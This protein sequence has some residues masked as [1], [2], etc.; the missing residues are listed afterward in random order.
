M[1]TKRSSIVLEWEVAV[2]TTD[3]PGQHLSFKLLSLQ[4]ARRPEFGHPWRVH[5]V[6]V[7]NMPFFMLSYD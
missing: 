2:E 1:K 6:Y 3:L 5:D 7:E 4:M